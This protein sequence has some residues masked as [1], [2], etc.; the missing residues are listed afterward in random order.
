M[1]LGTEHT[2][3]SHKGFIHRLPSRPTSISVDII[4]RMMILGKDV[5]KKTHL[6]CSLL[7]PEV[8]F[9]IAHATSF[10]ISNSAVTQ[11]QSQP[12]S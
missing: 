8:A 12:V 11:P 10:S 5:K 1:I 6:I 9:D 7:Q 4:E 3:R 2:S